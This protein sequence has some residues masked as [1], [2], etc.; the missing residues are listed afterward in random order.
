MTRPSLVA[1]ARLLY[2]EVRDENALLVPE[3]VVLLN[4]TAA[5]VLELCNGARSL[6]EIISALS[7]RY[8]GADVADDVRELLDAMAQR[9]LLIDAAA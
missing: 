7:L 8:H 1:G 5:E 9:G 6:D 4:S 3:G 2:D